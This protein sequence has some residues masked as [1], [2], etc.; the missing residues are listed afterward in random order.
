M[1]SLDEFQRESRSFSALSQS[2]KEESWSLITNT[3]ALPSISEVDPSATE[4]T[5]NDGIRCVYHILYSVYSNTHSSSKAIQTAGLCLSITSGPFSEHPVIGL[6]FY[7]VHPC[8]T[9]A[10]LKDME[11]IRR[12]GQN[13]IAAWLT[14]TGPVAGLNFSH[15]FIDIF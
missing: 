12:E 3:E 2:L 9:S 7:F 8:N 15:A 14:I 11:H 10:L 5:P 13:K 6:P 1:L 4:I